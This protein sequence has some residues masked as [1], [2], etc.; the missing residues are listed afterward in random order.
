MIELLALERVDG[1]LFFREDGNVFAL[2]PP[3]RERVKVTEAGAARAVGDHGFEAIHMVFSSMAEMI[4]FVRSAQREAIAL[5]GRAEPALAEG[6]L[7]VA[8]IKILEG[9]LDRAERELL[10]T[11]SYANAERLLT[12]M[13][14]HAVNLRCA[15]ELESRAEGLLR[16]ARLER[17]MAKAPA[18]R[19]R[20]I[21]DVY[22]RRT[23][24]KSNADE[25]PAS[26]PG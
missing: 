8:P 14:S 18:P 12:T 26:H 16:R 21:D 24:G 7:R 3:Y 9:F 11:R 25:S 23:F 22:G 20:L 19:R 10:P 1:L 4:A 6:L 13:L 17:I 15:P 5:D 2:R